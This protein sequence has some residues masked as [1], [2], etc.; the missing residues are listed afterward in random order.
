MATR[1]IKCPYDEDSGFRFNRGYLV[2]DTPTTNYPEK[3]IRFDDMFEEVTSYS[4]LRVNLTP[5]SC[6]LLSQT[7]ISDSEGFV[8]FILV[9]SVFP[10][11]TL[12]TRKYLTW[13]YQGGIYNMGKIMVLTGSN[14]T[15]FSSESAGWNISQPG[16]VYND[17]GIIFC[18]PHS[19]ITIKL[20]ILIAR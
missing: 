20:E 14:I 3:F 7:D 11:N 10:D 4:K 17:G 18:N 6:Y 16:T 19:D 2:L 8:S 1:P 15:D 13:E 12:E 9:K 5:S